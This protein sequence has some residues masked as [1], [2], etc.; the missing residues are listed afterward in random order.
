MSRSGDAYIEAL[1]ADRVP[2]ADS[3]LQQC[4]QAARVFSGA[5][6]GT[7]GT[8]AGMVLH[9]L[10]E[11]RRLKVELAVERAR[12]EMLDTYPH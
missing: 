8:L 3:Y 12:R 11:I 2:L 4:E 10:R 1:N 5:Y 7:A 6:T 9:C